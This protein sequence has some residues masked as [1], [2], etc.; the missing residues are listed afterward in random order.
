MLCRLEMEVEACIKA[1]T[2]MMEDVFGRRAKPMDWKLNVK[3]QFSAESL[4]KAVKRLVPL[5]ED[6]DR[7]LLNDSRSDKRPCRAYVLCCR[8]R[9]TM[10]TLV[11]F[12]CAVRKSN[13][14][15]ARLRSYACDAL[16]DEGD[17]AIW[18][19]ARATSAATSFFDPIIVGE[20][21]AGREYVDGAFGFNNPLD[22]VW[23]EALDIWKP[24][25][26]RLEP[27]LKCVVSIGTGNLGT[28]P[29][30]DK[31]WS[32]AKALKDIAT[33]TENTERVFAM[34]HQDLLG[35]ERRYFRF[36]VDQGLQSVGLEEY[37]R[38]GEIIDATAKYL[39]DHQLVR[40]QF[41]DCATN[42]SR[43]ECMLVEDFS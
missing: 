9:R 29:V 1:Y 43:K 31:P 42:L 23:L 40:M 6:P 4:E 30:G 10:L 39:N 27:M 25:Q 5:S 7:A 16:M 35:Q 2:D 32:I 17:I 24:E 19:A 3:G 28:S 18:Q 36:N 21:Y 34:R 11:R 14:S 41:Q 37:K 22:E 12:V 15:L 13:K 8:T 33:Q 38:Q 20:G 26:G